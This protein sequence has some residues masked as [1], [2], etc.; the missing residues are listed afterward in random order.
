MFAVLLTAAMLTCS[1]LHLDANDKLRATV[2]GVPNWM[3]REH[4]HFLTP[5]VKSDRSKAEKLGK[6]TQAG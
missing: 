3:T 2:A 5:G 6:A 1:T 4:L